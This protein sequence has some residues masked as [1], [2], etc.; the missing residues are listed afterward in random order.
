[1]RKVGLFLLTAAA[2]VSLTAF[3]AQAEEPTT[4][5]DRGPS[6]TIDAEKMSFDQPSQMYIAEGNVLIRYKNATLRAD[7]VKFN[8]ETKDAWADGNARLNRVGQEWVAPS[9]FYNF[10]THALK[11]DDARGFIDPLFFHAQEFQQAG[12]NYYTFARGTVTTCDYDPPHYHWEATHGEIWPDDRV[13]LYNATLR[14]GNTPVFWFPMVIWALKSD[15]PPVVLSVG[16]DSRW[17]FFLLSS[18]TWKLNQDAALTVHLDE[19][20]RRGFGTGADL[21]YRLGST[22]EGLLRGYYID[23]ARPMDTTDV[24]KDNDHLR[25]RG[26]WQHKQDL[27]DDVTLTVDLN[28]LSDPDVI[29]DFFNS[30]FNH[31]REPDSVADITKRGPNYTLSLLV[32]PQLNDFFAEV[33]RLPE[34]KLAIDRTRLGNT[35]FFYEGESSVGEFHNEPGDTGDTNFVGN[36]VRVDTFHQIV[37]PQMLGG[38]LSVIPRAGVRATY[39]SRAPEDAPVTQDVTRVVYDLGMETSFKLSRSWDEVHSD[40]LRIDGLRHILQPFADYQWVPRPNKTP[41]ELFQFDSTRDVMLRG[42]DTLSLTRYSPLE[43]PSYNTID[44]IDAE[45]TVRFGLRQTLQTRREGQAWNLVDL[46]GWTDWRMEK[47]K[48]QT[49]FSDFFGTLELRP[50]EWLSLDAFAR[51]GLND[52]VLH[53]FNTSTRLLDA[54]RWSFGVGTRY[55]KD[56]S[57]LVSADLAY[58]LSRH[59]TAEVRERVDLQD[60]TWEEQEYVLRQETHDWFIDY[61]FRYHAQRTRSDDMTVFFSVT[62]KAYPGYKLSVK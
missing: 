41:D 12:T 22:G 2:V 24:G 4:S 9:L 43:F 62:L 15:T 55:L 51:Y 21:Q 28:K 47:D 34:A 48:G 38:W 36:A 27:S 29:D 58:R 7:R 42:G 59:W 6:A 25:Y 13:V 20:T 31:N 60:G 3:V 50:W 46:T 5:E 35:P 57:N 45:H 40:W 37:A 17:G 23:D 19:R 8:V 53:E 10:D 26:E 16:T 49:D 30:E 33:E 1:M 44:T 18:V 14:F 54:D 32:R 61:G 39:Y 56:D 11:T 52:G